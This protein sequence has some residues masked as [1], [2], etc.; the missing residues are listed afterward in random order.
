MLNVLRTAEKT[1]FLRSL[2]NTSKLTKEGY[3]FVC[4]EGVG[5]WRAKAGRLM[6]ER[7]QGILLFN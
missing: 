3:Q 7:K 4:V 1:S 6:S 2:P 5:R